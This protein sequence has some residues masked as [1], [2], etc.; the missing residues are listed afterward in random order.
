MVFEKRR[1][2]ERQLQKSPDS[3]RRT[4][5]S[6]T[7]QTIIMKEIPVSVIDQVLTTIK[8]SPVGPAVE[9]FKLVVLVPLLAAAEAQFGASFWTL[10]HISV[11]KLSAYIFAQAKAS[12][13][14]GATGCSRTRR[15]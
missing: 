8:D 4:F 1:G 2:C 11:F 14:N 5:P 3:R 6:A 13:S 15:P 7:S 12:T 10:I 9:H